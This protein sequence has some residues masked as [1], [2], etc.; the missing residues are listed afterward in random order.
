MWWVL[1]VEL[2]E[3]SVLSELVEIFLDAESVMQKAK[4]GELD[5]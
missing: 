5:L 4:L 1:E 3:I 2:W